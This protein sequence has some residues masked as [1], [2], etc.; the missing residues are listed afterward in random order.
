M[1]FRK[2][3]AVLVVGVLLMATLGGCAMGSQMAWPDRE[4]TVDLDTALM[5]QDAGMA[6]LMMGKVEWTESEFSS[7]L[8][9]LLQQN[10]GEN[11][12]VDTIQAWF[13]PDNKVF[14]RVNLKEGVLLGGNTLDL[15]GSI[16]VQ[17]Q[18]LMVALDEV[19][20]NGYSAGGLLL[21]PIADQIN[22][23]LSGPQFGVAVDVAT[24][25]GMLSVG[26]AGM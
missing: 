19:G 9:Y 11:F 8:T 21:Q 4:L 2:F 23:V 14:L 17:D 10:T 15:A 16:G 22:A 26:L 1:Q 5:A 6:A 24:D 13:E 18:H 3:W 25:T 7:F 12:P 20:A